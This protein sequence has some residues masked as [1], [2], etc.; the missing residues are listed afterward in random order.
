MV[1]IFYNNQSNR[2]QT[3]EDY[4]NL[5]E[6]KWGPWEW[7]SSQLGHMPSVVNF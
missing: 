4:A 3:L 7:Q 1:H 6:D 2:N 5:M